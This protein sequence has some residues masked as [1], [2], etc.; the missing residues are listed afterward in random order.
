MQSIILRPL[1]R[2]LSLHPRVHQLSVLVEYNLPSLSA[3]HSFLQLRTAARFNLL[4]ATSPVHDLFA[5]QFLLARG[6]SQY[7]IYRYHNDLLNRP[8]AIPPIMST[9]RLARSRLQWLIDV[10]DTLT[11]MHTRLPAAGAPPLRSTLALI[12]THRAWCSS[13][14]GG[15]IIRFIRAIFHPPSNF[16][17]LSLEPAPAQRLRARLRMNASALNAYLHR[18][19]PRLAPS[20][21]CVHCSVQ[22]GRNTPETVAHVLLVCACYATARDVLVDDVERLLRR[23]CPLTLALILDPLSMPGISKNTRIDLLHITS[24]FISAV[25]EKR[26]L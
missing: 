4:P 12:N 18:R 11:G 21:S 26:G 9:L 6:V 24:R 8:D 5:Y 19:C 25:H 2:A 13:G 10:R 17:Y 3:Y 16:S 14:S 15:A 1:R 22:L 23:P 20:P 7:E